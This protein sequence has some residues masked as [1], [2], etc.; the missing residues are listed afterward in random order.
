MS[1]FFLRFFGFGHLNRSVVRG[2]VPKID[3]IGCPDLGHKS[4]IFDGVGH[5]RPVFANSDISAASISG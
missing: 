5:F 4:A 1:L 3:K 2:L